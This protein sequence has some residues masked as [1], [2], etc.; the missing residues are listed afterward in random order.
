MTRDITINSG[1]RRERFWTGTRYRFGLYQSA[2]LE[3]QATNVE[4]TC[5][6]YEALAQRV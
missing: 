5:G 2:W 4:C 1:E 3:K 6:D